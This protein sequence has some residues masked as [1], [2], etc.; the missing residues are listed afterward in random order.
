M[1]LQLFFITYLLLCYGRWMQKKKFNPN[2]GG[3]DGY[4]EPVQTGYWSGSIRK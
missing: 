4:R 3:N 1:Q 2:H